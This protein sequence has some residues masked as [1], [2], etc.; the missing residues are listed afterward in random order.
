MVQRVHCRHL[1]RTIHLHHFPFSTISIYL[2]ISIYVQEKKDNN[3]RVCTIDNRVILIYFVA[4]INK[5][6]IAGTVILLIRKG[7]SS[8]I[9][10]FN[11]ELFF[12]YL[13]P[14]II[15]NAGFQVKKKHFFQNFL[16]IMLFGVAGVFISTSII[17]T[18]SWL[19]FSMLDIVGLTVRDYL[20]I[21][22][23]F[24]ATDTV[25]TLQAS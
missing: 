13:L 24:S 22:A 1:H 25:C 2:S 10:R 17:S 7:K 21:G 14:P 4:L 16:T 19:L 5:G 8:H 18:G 23:I 3:F 12:I 9:L 15:F 11:E 6:F 20:A